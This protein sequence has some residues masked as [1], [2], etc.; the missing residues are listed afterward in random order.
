MIMINL[1]VLELHS[2]GAGHCTKDPGGECGDQGECHQVLQGDRRH[3]RLRQQTDDPN[4]QDQRPPAGDR[5]L[6]GDEEQHV[7][8]HPGKLSLN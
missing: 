3:P 7:H 4:L 2:E 8:L 6:A 1:Q 5:V